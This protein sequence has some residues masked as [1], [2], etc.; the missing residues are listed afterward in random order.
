MSSVKGGNNDHKNNTN[1]R[2]YLFN[3]IKHPF[4]NIQWFYTSTGEIEKIIKS[5]K[6]KSLVVTMKSLLKS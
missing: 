1:P 4:P 3:S 2:K 6:T 5:L